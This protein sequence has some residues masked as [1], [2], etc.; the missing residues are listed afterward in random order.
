MLSYIK[1]DL[2]SHRA[3]GTA[4]L[5]HA[6]NPFGRWGG[7]IAAQFREQYPYA[8]NIYVEH[9][10]RHDNLLGKC[11]L[12]P[13]TASETE[14]EVMIAC[15]FTSDFT[16]SQEQTLEYTRRAMDD[17]ERQLL[18]ITPENPQNIEKDSSG[19]PT[20][21]MPQINSGIFRVPWEQTADIL[22]SCKA[23]RINVYTL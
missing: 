18:T 2:F 7:G 14:A 13:A 15:L 6:C 20:V 22:E 12:V 23:L 9:C 10:L 21:N 16:C 11:L 8:Y 4:I 5:A 19:R 17:L 3:A 1:G